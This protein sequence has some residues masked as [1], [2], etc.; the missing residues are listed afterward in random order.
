MTGTAPH[1]ERAYATESKADVRARP[2]DGPTDLACDAEAS[3]PTQL[4]TS[5]RPGSAQGRLLD[6]R[7]LFKVRVIR[8]PGS[9]RDSV[10]LTLASSGGLLSAGGNVPGTLRGAAVCQVTTDDERQTPWVL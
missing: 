4:V 3:H 2:R 7:G 10:P 9:G 8:A 5:R 6:W 1:G